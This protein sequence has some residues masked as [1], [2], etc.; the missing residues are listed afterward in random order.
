[1]ALTVTG[2]CKIA[3]FTVVSLVTEQ[4]RAAGMQTCGCTA[5]VVQHGRRQ[6][7]ARVLFA[8]CLSLCL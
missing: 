6:G 1:M 3:H 2:S 7:S 4:R 5:F 8:I